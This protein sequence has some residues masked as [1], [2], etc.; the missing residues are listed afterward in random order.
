MKLA[1]DAIGRAPVRRIADGGANG[2]TA[3]H[4]SQPQLAHQAL[5]RAA[6]GGEAIPFQ[7]PPYLAHSID[8]KV[9]EEHSLHLDLQSLVALGPVG[10]QGRVA[11]FGGVIVVRGWGD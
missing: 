6:G 8:T 5:H 9:L 1:M 3:N 2:L 4:S 10:Q 7:L 11:S